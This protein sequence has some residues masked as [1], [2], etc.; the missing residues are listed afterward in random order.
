MLSNLMGATV[1]L[2]NLDTNEVIS[3]VTD[4]NGE[5]S[6][7]GLV[8]GLYTVSA[9]KDT[10]IHK[11]GDPDNTINDL[12]PLNNNTELIPFIIDVSD[13]KI[14]SVQIVL[15][16]E[17]VEYV[18]TLT[19]TIVDDP[20]GSGYGYFIV[21]TSN[22][23]VTSDLS[24]YIYHYIPTRSAEGNILHD[25]VLIPSGNTFSSNIY[26]IDANFTATVIGEQIN[27]RV[28]PTTALENVSVVNTLN[29][30]IPDDLTYG[31]IYL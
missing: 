31:Y 28:E 12:D 18:I 21:A 29:E 23:P 13:E 3:L 2:K 8:N 22:I 7:T 16:K 19:G 5:V 24:F 20:G 11:A 15:I 25:N 4:V 14:A 26:N 1:K 30:P 6:F 17:E 10:Y 27:V 9:E